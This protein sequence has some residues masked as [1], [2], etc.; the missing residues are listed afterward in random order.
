M[1]FGLAHILGSQTRLTT[2][3]ALIGS[4]A[5]MAPEV[6]DGLRA[7][8]RADLYSLGT[9]LYYVL[10][11]K[12]PFEAPNPSALF[13]K[14]LEGQYESPQI[15]NPA[16]GNSLMRI[17]DRSLAR[18]PADRYQDVSELEQDLLRELKTVLWD[19]SPSL[20]SEILRTPQQVC[21]DK[22]D[23][24]VDVLIGDSQ[25]A[26][27]A[28]DI[29]RAADR[30][31]RAAALRPDH[32][33]ISTLM[34]RLSTARLMG[35][36]QGTKILLGTGLV[37]SIAS[38]LRLVT[39]P[40]TYQVIQTQHAD[41]EHRQTPL[42]SSQNQVS[43][44]AGQVVLGQTRFN[45]EDANPETSTAAIPQGPNP[46]K[47][48]I[49]NHRPGKKAA[50]SRLNPQNL[51]AKLKN[52]HPNSV[53]SSNSTKNLDSPSNGITATHQRRNQV[54]SKMRVA[55]QTAPITLEIRIGQ[56]YANIVVDNEVQLTNQ[57][58]AQLELSPGIH[59][60]EII[61]PNFGRFMPRKLEVSTKGE[62]FELRPSGQKERLSQPYLDF[63]IPLSEAEARSMEFW[64]PQPEEG[65][66]SEP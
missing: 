34:K 33:Q 56:S 19:T 23:A 20:T 10:L 7:D 12:L 54:A 22:L 9:I 46:S 28:G 45:P 64:V 39:H 15:S 62:V 3:G 32:P 26:L 40:L 16:V 52:H 43:K 31:N 61:K 49:S 8:H 30:I 4:P 44:P 2:T 38:L 50:Q 59:Q 57:Y 27:K 17:V 11:G 55:D 36:N 63:K 21:S 14:I 41:T 42:P 24:T 51:S 6:I 35:W 5:H 1:D 65:S 66:N 37:L 13:R 25:S 58:R 29:A 48:K 47:Q 53:Q 18:S 60:I